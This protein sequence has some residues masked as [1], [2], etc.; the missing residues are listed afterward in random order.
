METTALLE[1]LPNVIHYRDAVDEV[2]E[3]G[4]RKLVASGELMRISRGVYQK[5]DHLGNSNYIEIAERVPEA[6][7]CLHSALVHHNLIDDIPIAIDIAVPRNTWKRTFI[8]PVN[9]HSFD[10]ER[11]DIGR[12]LWTFEGGQLHVY[13]PE[14]A[15]V[16]AIRLHRY[17]GP[18]DGIIAIKTWLYNGGKPNKL[19]DISRHF[20]SADRNIL[21]YLEVLL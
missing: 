12:E 20:P 10:R 5:A 7:L 13:S 15:I 9:W 3:Y 16:D 14:R 4:L 8:S 21:Q 2:G 1:R 17:I 19:L 18:D 11:F 6:T